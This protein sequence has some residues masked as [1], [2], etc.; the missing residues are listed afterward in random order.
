MSG[1]RRTALFA[2]H[3]WNGLD[4]LDVADDQRS[5]CVHFFNGIP[6][7]LSV[8]HV[9]IAG[10]R[11]I[12]DI[13]VLR[14]A[15][16]P[17]HDEEVDDC[18]RIDL[19]RAGDFS[20]YTLCLIDVPG[21]DPRFRCL[22][23]SFKTQC[24][25]DL[26]C[27]DAAACPT[28]PVAAIYVDYLAKDYASFRPLL[29][30]RLALTLPD[31]RERHVPDPGVT[32]VELLAYAGD[33]LSYQQD[34]VATEAYLATARRRI[35]VRRHLRLID[36]ALHEGCN[37]RAFVTV[38]TSADFTVARAGDMTFLTRADGV[39]T[40]GGGFVVADMLATRSAPDHV[41]FEPL[42]RDG[43]VTFRA[44]HGR[45][46]FHDW[47]EDEC[48]LPRGATA[49]TLVDG[50]LDDAAARLGLSVGDW[51]IFE[52][53]VGPTTGNPADAD[54]AHRHVV[55]LTT[56]T[57]GRDALL[58]VAVVEIE[59]A[60]EDALPFAL[61][62]SSRR[63]APDCDRVREVSVARGNVV[64]VDHGQTFTQV[65]DPVPGVDLPGECACEGSV[66][67]VRRAAGSHMP[68]LSRASLTF[69]EPVAAGCSA[70]ALLIRDPRR[71]VAA[72]RV[73]DDG[74][75]W[76]PR[77]DLLASDGDARDVV[78]EVDDDG[79][80]HLRFGDGT[81]GG[82]PDV[83]VAA[84]ATARAGNGSS[85]NVGREAIALLALSGERVDGVEITVRNPIAASGGTAAE[86]MGE[87]R[88]FAPGLIQ[89]RRER[90]I[91]ADDYAELAVRE[92]PTLQGA[93][94]TLRWTGSWHEA[95]VAIDPLHRD[96]APHALI[97]AV[98]EALR[99]YR[100]I[101]HDLSVTAARIVPLRLA[102]RVCVL[103]H[104]RA[105]AVK[106][107]LLEVF[108][109]GLR[110]DGRPGFFHP[111]RMRFGA[112]VASSQVIAA[113]M[114]VEGIETVRVTAL[115]RLDRPG[116]T[117]ALDTG[118]LL[119]RPGEIAQLANDPDYPEHGRLAFE[120]GGGR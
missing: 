57:P 100:R 72:V 14:I 109:A 50:Y 64:A 96:D 52:E 85:G 108:S 30:D 97:A 17:S 34:A 24:P 39:A 69:A 7:G 2:A 107:A 93:A 56:V 33:Q 43:A 94:A 38:A 103:P 77:A 48:C 58:G 47:G 42:V 76:T 105:A 117:T 86:A 10:G 26:D 5:L 19:D 83:G 101:G 75:S 82:A 13:R 25:G 91:V 120:M 12:R 102:M 6:D 36:Y 11:R 23:F 71:A 45:I 3:D 18:L 79:I 16:D 98:T 22:D 41:V 37:A 110:G 92:T 49:A 63:P 66:I 81:H 31:W 60:A 4:Y 40:T 116:D 74:G 1:A 15:R 106:R 44:A 8:A 118:Q 51:L 55:R 62:L 88:L 28:A 61:C 27:G 114:A 65:L 104:Y 32:L 111:D 89:A 59:W 95:Q 84:R 53:V 35:S 112:P 29:L 119:L 99:G 87:A 115:E 73:D 80:A 54:P 9:R 113:A 68:V 70:A 20:T 21:I 67:E 46:A 90:A 78:V